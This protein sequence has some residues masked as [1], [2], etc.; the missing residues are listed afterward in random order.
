MILNKFLDLQLQSKIILWDKIQETTVDNA[1]VNITFLWNPWKNV[2]PAS[3]SPTNI[4]DVS[5]I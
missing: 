2:F 4:L 5:G 1:S 3:I